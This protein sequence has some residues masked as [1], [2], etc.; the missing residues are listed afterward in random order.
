MRPLHISTVPSAY[1]TDVSHLATS[2]ERI[3]D[4]L[5]PP[6]P[7]ARPELSPRGATP[8][9]LRALKAQL[10]AWIPSQLLPGRGRNAAAVAQVHLLVLDYDQGADPE[11]ESAR[12]GEWAHVVH[13]TW[14]HTAAHPK[15]RLVLPLQRPVSA[16]SWGRVFE[17]ASR[18]AEGQIDPQTRNAD[19]LYFL[20]AVRSVISPWESWQVEGRWLTID[21]AHLRPTAEELQQARRRERARAYARRPDRDR[22]RAEIETSDRATRERIATELGAH[23]QQ[24]GIATGITCPACGRPDVWFALEPR[25][26]GRAFCNHRSSCGWT[27]PLKE[28]RP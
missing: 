24:R 22:F 5:S 28:L 11:A 26:S 27:G 2:W 12:W 9:R 18:F 25:T 15:F 21:P 17:W 14:G 10:P 16:S 8:D 13:T 20:P 6:T 4:M 7:P 19:R 1:S 3:A 23:I